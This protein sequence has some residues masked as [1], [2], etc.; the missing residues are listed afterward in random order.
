MALAW[1]AGWVHALAGSNPASSATCEGDGG[2]PVAPGHRGIFVSL[3]HV[4][5]PR[6]PESARPALPDSDAVSLNQS[7][8]QL[9]IAGGAG[10]GGLAVGH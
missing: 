7:S 10:I 2:A 8:M 3:P 6:I 5:H 4:T 1:N 9:G